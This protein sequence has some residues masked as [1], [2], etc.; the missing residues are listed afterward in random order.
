[1]KKLSLQFVLIATLASACGEPLSET[2]REIS[3][4]KKETRRLEKQLERQGV[5][6]PTEAER[7]QE[8]LNKSL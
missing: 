6:I 2:E 7:Q 8:Y 5:R 4:A 1:M 3:R